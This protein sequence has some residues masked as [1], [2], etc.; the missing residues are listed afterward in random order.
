MSEIDY[1]DVIH[2]ASNESFQRF[3]QEKRNFTHLVGSKNY[4]LIAC[5]YIMFNLPE[6]IDVL[7]V[8]CRNLM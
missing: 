8:F 1:F 2:K 5:L 7:K 4:Y 6:L 3:C